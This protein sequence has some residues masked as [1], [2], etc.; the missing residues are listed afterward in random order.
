MALIRDF[1]FKTPLEAAIHWLPRHK[2]PAAPLCLLAEAPL[3]PTRGV[4]EELNRAHMYAP[5][6]TQRAVLPLYALLA[7]RTPLA[8]DEWALVPTPCPRLGGALPA[9][10]GRFAEEASHLVRHLPAADR[11]RLRTAALCLA[12]AERQLVQPLPPTIMESLLAAAAAG[13]QMLP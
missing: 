9:V 7:A 10:L 1:S 2:E 5:D 12:R 6:A 11:Q 4:L 8:A 3:P 13:W